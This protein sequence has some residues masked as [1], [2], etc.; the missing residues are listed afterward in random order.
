MR[1]NLAFFYRNFRLEALREGVDVDVG[2]LLGLV[3]WI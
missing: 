2:Q 1:Q 3:G